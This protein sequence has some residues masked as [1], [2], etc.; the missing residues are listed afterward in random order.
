MPPQRIIRLSTSSLL[1]EAS[2]PVSWRTVP[3]PFAH[4]G[5]STVP[6]ESWVV[7]NNSGAPCEAT[8]AHKVRKHDFQQNTIHLHTFQLTKTKNIRH[9][10]TLELIQIGGVSIALSGYFT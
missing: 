7:V 2:P 1:K 4:G 9:K 8:V 5:Q 10:R 6:E 3:W